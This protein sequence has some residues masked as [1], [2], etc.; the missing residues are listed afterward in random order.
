MTP[1][2]PYRI[3]HE[4][5]A[6][7][8]GNTDAGY[9]DARTLYG[10]ARAGERGTIATLGEAIKLCGELATEYGCKP[11]DF[12]IHD[13]AGMTVGASA[14]AEVIRAEVDAGMREYEEEILHVDIDGNEII[15]GKTD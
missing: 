14:V 9:F 8:A 12:D 1:K 2:A 13:R 6:N 3:F 15:V 4:D 5:S 11:S 7:A 10:D